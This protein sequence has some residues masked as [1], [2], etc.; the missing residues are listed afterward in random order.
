MIER[1]FGRV[2]KS[3]HPMSNIV[4]LVM[5]GS[6]VREWLRKCLSLVLPVSNVVCLVMVG[7][8]VKECLGDAVRE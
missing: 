8:D 6:A 2:S 1:E 7:D 3:M 5:A 4:C